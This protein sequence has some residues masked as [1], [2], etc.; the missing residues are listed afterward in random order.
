MFITYTTGVKRTG[1]RDT[2]AELCGYGLHMMDTP[3]L[4]YEV[5]GQP[6]LPLLFL[7]WH[8]DFFYSKQQNILVQ[9]WILQYSTQYD[10]TAV[11]EEATPD[12]ILFQRTP[13]FLIGINRMPIL[14]K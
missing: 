5:H 14:Y 2:F 13:R 11:V 12:E 7:F 9:F 10:S 3:D 1:S 8:F 6:E 4:Y